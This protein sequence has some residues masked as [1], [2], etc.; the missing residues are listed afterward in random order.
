M[1]DEFERLKRMDAIERQMWIDTQRERAEE[2]LDE[3][4][5]DMERRKAQMPLHYSERV[6]PAT[7][8][9]H[10]EHSTDAERTA[11]DVRGWVQF[12]DTRIADAIERQHSFMI[13]ILGEMLASVEDTT[14]KLVAAK[15]AEL[16]LDLVNRM[17]D[18]LTSIKKAAGIS[19]PID[20]PAWPKRNE[21]TSVN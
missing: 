8:V 4:R 7:D 11:N 2:G 17:F 15:T 21:P 10:A 3:L 18:T 19:E 16:K 12:I 9:R 5:A 6:E 1:G 13:E 14:E 20:L